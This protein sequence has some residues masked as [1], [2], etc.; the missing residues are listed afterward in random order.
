MLE[1][2]S[3][4]KPKAAIEHI[5]D[6]C[7]G[8]INKGEIYNKANLKYDGEFYTWKNHIKCGN[9]ANDLNMFDDLWTDGLTSEDFGDNVQDF[10][11]N[12]LPEDHE[13]LYWGEAAVDKA[14]E[15]LKNK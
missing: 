15:I 4:S 5:C 1:I 14:I 11:N 13:V 8:I 7:G 9:L 2:L 12:N 10:L 3:T 6:Y